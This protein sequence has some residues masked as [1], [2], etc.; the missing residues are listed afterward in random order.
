MDENES[1]LLPCDFENTLELFPAPSQGDRQ[2]TARLRTPHLTATHTF[3]ELLGMG[4]GDF[5]G[6]VELFD[7]F[8]R[9]WL[10]WDGTRKWRSGDDDFAILGT[11]DRIKQ[12]R[13]GIRIRNY[14]E[15]WELEDI[16]VLIEGGHLE[17][18]A[19]AVRSFVQSLPP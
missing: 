5:E 16:P 10:G 2:L 15:D 1:R 13:L 7:A 8:A 17:A 14:Y 11:H 19:R 9:D 3:H 18:V 6:I 12:A 4:V